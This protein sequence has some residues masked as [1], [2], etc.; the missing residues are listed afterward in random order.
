M[1]PQ[2]SPETPTGEIFRYTL[3]S[4]KDALGRDIYT[5]SDLKAVQDYV[6]QRELLRVQRVAGVTGFGGTVKRYEVQPDP[7]Q[8]A[9][10]NLTL[11]QLQA[12]G[13]EEG[14]G[15]SSKGGPLRAW[16]PGVGEE[17]LKAWA[18]YCRRG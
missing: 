1:T 7:Y 6:V 9:R 4:P 18:C 10:Y 3:R 16:Q 8:L 12:A 15:Q 5:L 14:R 17:G 2:L 13:G 11:A